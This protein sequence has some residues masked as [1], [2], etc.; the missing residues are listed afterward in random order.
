ML[1]IGGMGNLWAPLLGAV[2]LGV[3]PELFRPIVDYRMLFYTG[4]LLLMIRFQPGGLLGE[5]SFLRR[6]LHLK[7]R[8]AAA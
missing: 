5:G 2:I 7:P 8:R 4:L 1:V 3:L 6:R